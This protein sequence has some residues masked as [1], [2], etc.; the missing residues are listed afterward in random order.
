MSTSQK[1]ATDN[2]EDV[3][4][5]DKKNSSEPFIKK[6]RDFLV[7]SII[8]VTTHFIGLPASVMFCIVYFTL[9]SWFK[10]MLKQ[11]KKDIEDQQQ[12]VPQT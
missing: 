2:I 12:V 6:H 9:S 11:V 4:E 10:S 8:V 5:E 1:K 7:V 3:Q